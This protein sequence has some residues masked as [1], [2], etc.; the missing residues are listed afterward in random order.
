MMKLFQ[1]YALT[2]ISPTDHH[3][4]GSHGSFESFTG[5][6]LLFTLLIYNQLINFFGL[7]LFNK[8]QCP[9]L[10]NGKVEIV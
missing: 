2:S 8:K 4:H 5:L 3:D 6:Y 9:K 10:T 1:Y 7:L